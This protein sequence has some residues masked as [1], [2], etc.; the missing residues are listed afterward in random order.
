[1]G[2]AY[3]LANRK[4]GRLTVLN[5]AKIKASH[6]YWKCKCECGNEVIVRGRSLVCG[7]TRSCGCLAKERNINA[8][9]KHG[10]YGTR[11][12]RIWD[13]MKTRCFNPKAKSYPNYGGKGITVCKEW[14]SFKSFRDWAICNGY[15]DSLTIDR[16]DSNKGYSPSNCRWADY[17]TQAN[18]RVSSHWIT[19]KGTTKTMKQWSNILNVPYDMLCRRLSRGWDFEKAITTPLQRKNR[20]VG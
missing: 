18:N 4:F 6:S 1:M 10:W 3:N 7:E 15:N 20:K 17:I 16:I 8:S 2:R 9:T 5:R 13:S 14:L 19:Y 12:Y 11:L